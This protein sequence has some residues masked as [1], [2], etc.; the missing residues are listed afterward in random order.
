MEV[1]KVYSEFNFDNK[2]IT[3]TKNNAQSAPQKEEKDP[4]KELIVGAASLAGVMAPVLAISK[5]RSGKVGLD[6]FESG[7]IIKN[8]ATIVSVSAGGVLGGLG[9][10]LLTAKDEQEKKA[11][12]KEALFNFMKVL[13][14]TSI[15]SSIL[16]FE[17]KGKVKSNVPK[18]LASVAG[19]GLGMPISQKVS[20]KIADETIYKGEKRPPERKLKPLDYLVHL[21]DMFSL[22][23]LAEFPFAKK[24]KPELALPLI[25]AF[26]GFETGTKGEHDDDAKP[27]LD[28]KA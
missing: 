11:R 16:A 28:K 9:A 5:L 12:K 10:G 19:I 15:S 24:L 26:C 1:P 21:D 20:E 27:K 8:C 7:S 18:V 3:I 4:K 17:K 6:I 22:A 13:I 23:V 2:N 25:Y 14:P